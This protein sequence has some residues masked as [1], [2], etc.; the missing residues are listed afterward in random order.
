MTLLILL[1]VKKLMKVCT[2]LDLGMCD[3]SSH[4]VALIATPFSELPSI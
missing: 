2:H 1:I 3:I 4:I